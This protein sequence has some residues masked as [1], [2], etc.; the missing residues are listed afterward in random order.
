MGSSV[1]PLGVTEAVVFSQ[2]Q[3][4][5]FRGS[6]GHFVWELCGHLTICDTLSVSKLANLR[7]RMV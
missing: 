2:V 4:P 1:H 5:G 3:L 7:G 6:F